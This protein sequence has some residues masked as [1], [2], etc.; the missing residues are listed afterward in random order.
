MTEQCLSTGAARA[1]RFAVK[2]DVLEIIRQMNVLQI[3]TVHAAALGHH[4]PRQFGVF[5]DAPLQLALAERE[6]V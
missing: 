6:A 1:V 2:N 5:L 4:R 3:D